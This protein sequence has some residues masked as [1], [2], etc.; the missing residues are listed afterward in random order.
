MYDIEIMDVHIGI[1]ISKFSYPPM[2]ICSNGPLSSS[3]VRLLL[4][5]NRWWVE[6][7]LEWSYPRPQ[8]DLL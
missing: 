6:L 3:V 5:R 1:H 2:G 4:C 8:R 7:V